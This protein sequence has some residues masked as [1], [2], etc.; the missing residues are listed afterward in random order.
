MQQDGGLVGKI[1]YENKLPRNA[2]NMTYGNYYLF[3]IFN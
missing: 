2:F 3:I 1:L